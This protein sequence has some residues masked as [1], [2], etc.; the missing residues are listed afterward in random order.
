MNIL[1]ASVI[2]QNAGW[3]AEWYLNRSFQK[4]GHT[5]TCID[6]R[7]QRYRLYS[8]FRNAPPSHIFF[9]QRGDHFP[10]NLVRQVKLPRVFW[11]SELLSRCRDQDDLLDSGLFDH[12]YVH[13]AA[14]RHTLIERGWV[15]P[16][17]CSVLLN[18][19]DET[20]FRPDSEIQKDI[21]VL[22]IG[23]LTPRRE[24]L[25]RE[26]QFHFPVTVISAYG[27]EMAGWLNRAKIVL[28]L[29]ADEFL[30]T[31]TRVFE[32]LG[33][34]AFLLSEALSSEIPFISRELVEAQG[35]SDLTDKIGYYLQH[36]QE[37]EAVAEAGYTA[38]LQRHTYTYRSQELIERFTTL[39]SDRTDLPKYPVGPGA[40]LEAFH[41]ME[42][43]QRAQVTALHMIRSAKRRLIPKRQTA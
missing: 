14:C 28:N 11:A 22:F 13:S 15:D 5:T 37:R 1:Y 25:L 18:G 3:G 43:A 32:A 2:E 6:F 9:L 40:G 39:L 38:A 34:R 21:D 41:L 4:L 12:I 20:I 35:L 31:E 29:H 30:D 7:Q 17:K 27:I 23:N 26:I 36:P 19:F 8:P 16:Q 42:I 24:K 33:C 10:V